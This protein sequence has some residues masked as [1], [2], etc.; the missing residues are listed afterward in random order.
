MI[1]KHEYEKQ[2]FRRRL[3]HF[4]FDIFPFFDLLVIREDGFI[5]LI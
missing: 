2:P 5:Y 1:A 4:I 3:C